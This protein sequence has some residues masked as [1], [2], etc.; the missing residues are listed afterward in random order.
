MITSDNIAFLA[1]LVSL[2]TLIYTFH[3]DSKNLKFNE[4]VSK[5]S[6]MSDFFK[7]LYFDIITRE[8][9]NQLNQFKQG[10]LSS[11]IELLE[12]INSTIFKILDNSLFYRYYDNNFY[13]SIKSL[14]MNLQ[15]EVFRTIN[16]IAC[17]IYREESTKIDK[18]VE[19][20]YKVLMSYYS[21]I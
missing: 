11:K 21:S 16:L 10:T 15:D 7:E 19:N 6:V 1:F 4:K 9:P 13:I 12:N 14:I 17:G 20:L 2:L 3:I 5:E 18:E 8:L